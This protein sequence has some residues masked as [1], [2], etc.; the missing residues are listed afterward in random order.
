MLVKL[1]IF[2]ILLVLKKELENVIQC[3]RLIKP[4][5]IKATPQELQ[6]CKELKVT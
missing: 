4:K 1:L 6:F 3:R 2:L 5:T